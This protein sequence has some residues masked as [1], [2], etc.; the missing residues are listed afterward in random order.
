[1]VIIYDDVPHIE[2]IDD[3]L[4]LPNVEALKRSK[5]RVKCVIP[6][7]KNVGY[8][9]HTFCRKHSKI[10]KLEKPEEC[11]ICMDSLDNEKY[12]LRADND[13]KVCG[14]WVHHSCVISSGKQECP[15][16]REKI[17][18]NRQQQGELNAI[19]TKHKKDKEAEERHEIMEALR[20]ER[21]IMSRNT[22]WIDSRRQRD[23]FTSR[24]RDV[25][26]R[27]QEY[28]DSDERLA[29]ITHLQDMMTSTTISLRDDATVLFELQSA[30]NRIN[31]SNIT[32]SRNVNNTFF[33]IMG[34]VELQIRHLV[35]DNL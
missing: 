17:K 4:I 27:V 33:R 9:Q 5:Q 7:C 3:E 30:L 11:P 26:R 13:E 18:L 29:T 14:H 24:S 32:V 35:S 8:G 16:C 20:V 10:Y 23:I 34:V 21:T 12:P 28:I 25:P 22:R 15:M 31:E 1:M 19:K 6:N 2:V